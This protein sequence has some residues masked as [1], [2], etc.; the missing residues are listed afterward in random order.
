MSSPLHSLGPTF[1]ISLQV[2][3]AS[4]STY[5]KLL[6]QLSQNLV[7]NAIRPSAIGKKN[8]LFI[9]HPKAGQHSAI[10]YSIVVSCKRRGIDRF[11]I[12]ATCC[13]V[14]RR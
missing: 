6:T 14:C 1:L 12:Y 3:V 13:A 4:L 9:G 11:N 2:L 7:E 10:I 8:W 5:P